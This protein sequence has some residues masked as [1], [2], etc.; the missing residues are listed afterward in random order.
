[1]KLF[2]HNFSFNERNLQNKTVNNTTNITDG[3]LAAELLQ[4]NTPPV[5]GN[6]T[7][8]LIKGKKILVTGAGGSI[9]SEIV[10][11]LKKIDQS[12]PIFFVD[13]DEYSL[14]K[15]QLSLTG[16]PLLNSPEY[17]LADITNRTKMHHIFSEIKPDLVFHAAAHKHLP[18][19]E[20]SP[21][22]AVKTNVLGTEVIAE[23]CALYGVGCLINISTDKAARPTSILGMTKRLAEMRAASFANDKTKIASVR[24]GNVLGSRGSFLETLSYQATKG[25]PITITDERMSRYFMTIP[26]AAGLVIE[27]S[28]IAESGS[29]YVLDMGEPV[30]II[31]LVQRY[32]QQFINKS[33]TIIFTGIRRGEKLHE[34]LF[35]PSETY[36]ETTHVRIRAVEVSTDLVSDKQLQR[37]YALAKNGASLEKLH[38]TLEKLI[39]IN[40]PRVTKTKKLSSIEFAEQY[41][42]GFANI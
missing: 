19:L 4:R 27:S 6:K 26:E 16:K 39:A 18:L 41:S 21:E 25:L 3:A 12:A 15:L 22:A 14:Y 28:A 35:D 38:T 32:H 31:D 11:Q 2:S 7:K 23:A 33:P 42:T 20:R 36:R 8:R 24:F 17:I 9:G 13:N 29:T 10:H 30:K 5:Y 37:L 1:M 40:K 34:E